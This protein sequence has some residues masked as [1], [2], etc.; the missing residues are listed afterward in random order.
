MQNIHP[1]MQLREIK[2]GPNNGKDT[3]FMGS[4]FI[5]KLIFPLNDL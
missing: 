4:I 1:K 5:K 3:M 2:D